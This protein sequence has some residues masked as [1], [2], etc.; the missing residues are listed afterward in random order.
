[1]SSDPR[2][3]HGQLIPPSRRGQVYQVKVICPYCK[4]PHFYGAGQD[5][6]LLGLRSP[7][8]GLGEQ[9]LIVVDAREQ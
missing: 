8:C 5:G 2:I 6:K 1:M 9:H 7:Q 3:V 4:K